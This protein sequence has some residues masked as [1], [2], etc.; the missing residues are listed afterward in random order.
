MDF[1]VEVV[2]TAAVVS[3]ALGNK[4]LDWEPLVGLDETTPLLPVRIEGAW[5]GA[6]VHVIICMFYHNDPA[7]T[8]GCRGIQV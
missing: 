4:L 1:G 8:G 6:T 5:D 7:A 3:E 2:P